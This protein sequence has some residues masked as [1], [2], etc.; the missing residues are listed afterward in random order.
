MDQ[1]GMKK[2]LKTRVFTVAFFRPFFASFFFFC[3][4]QYRMLDLDF[5]GFT[6]FL[7][8]EIE[9]GK[10]GNTKKGEKKEAKKAIVNNPNGILG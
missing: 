8:V 7:H 5:F 1:K 9:K 3:F 10:N 6:P 2:E 4:H